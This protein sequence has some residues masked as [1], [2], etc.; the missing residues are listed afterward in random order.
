MAGVLTAAEFDV[1]QSACPFEIINL[2]NAH[3]V[4]LAELVE[5]LERATGKTALRDYQPEQLGDV[6]RT[7]ADIGKARRLLGYEP[8]TPFQEGLNGFVEWYRTAQRG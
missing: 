5:S 6:P 3:P 4:T 2:G 7:W 1:V 8:K